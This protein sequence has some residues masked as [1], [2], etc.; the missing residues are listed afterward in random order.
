[1]NVIANLARNK[2]DPR[3]LKSGRSSLGA[4]DQLAR[5]L[6][7]LG[8]GLG[9]VQIAAPQHLTR[10]LGLRG[11]EPFVRACGAREIGTGIITLSPDKHTGLWARVAGDLMDIAALV[12]ALHPANPKRDNVKLAMAAVIGVT[13]LDVLGALTLG[14][15]HGRQVGRDRRFDN[16]SGFPKGLAAARGSAQGF[17]PNGG[18]GTGRGEATRTAGGL[19]RSTA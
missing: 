4:A 9:L 6:G 2:G 19:S 5:T 1:M 8:I 12:P 15:R 11:M 10:A 3:I 7:W 13:A 16:R 18:H 14:A 17:K